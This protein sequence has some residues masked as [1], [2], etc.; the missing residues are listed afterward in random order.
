MEILTERLKISELSAS[1][2]SDISQ[3]ALDMAWNDTLNLLIRE[4]IDEATFILT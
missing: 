2:L 1:D 3:I 4:D